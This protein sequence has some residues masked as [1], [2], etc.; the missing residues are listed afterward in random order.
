M[1]GPE[2]HA[3]V[4]VRARVVD[5]AGR[6][7]RRPSPVVLDSTLSLARASGQGASGGYTDT[8]T[9]TPR[10]VV[11][12][13]CLVHNTED[14]RRGRAIRDAGIHFEI[15]KKP[16]P[17]VQLRSEALG[18]NA[19]SVSP[20]RATDT[21]EVASADGRPLTLG[22]PRSII[23]QRNRVPH[24]NTPRFNWDAGRRLKPSMYTVED[25]GDRYIV[26]VRP[27]RSGRLGPSFGRAIKVSLLADVR[28]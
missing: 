7:P 13:A 22:R 23:V 25:R 9:V 15:P 14:F 28:Q 6:A 4:V 19:T 12:V 18:A 3:L 16:A 27:T 5:A 2:H 21:A 1:G 10:D 26:T 11:E 17:R 8:V 24:G 20:Y